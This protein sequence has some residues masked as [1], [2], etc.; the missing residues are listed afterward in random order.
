MHPN[1]KSDIAS[2]PFHSNSNVASSV[3][4]S[5]S[6]L[7]EAAAA[8]I[9]LGTK[10]IQLSKWNQQGIA[11]VCKDL[12]GL[13]DV[14]AV[15]INLGTTTIQLGQQNQVISLPACF[16]LTNRD[17]QAIDKVSQRLDTDI[18]KSA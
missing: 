18:F 6:D 16:N 17:K 7:K 13:K 3:A 8:S 9:N 4:P 1:S 14:V 2:A 5:L 15:G 11:N 12:G 10:A